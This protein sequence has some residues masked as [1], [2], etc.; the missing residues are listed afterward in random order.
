VSITSIIQ[1]NVYNTSILAVWAAV[2]SVAANDILFRHSFCV[3]QKVNSPAMIANALENRADVWSSLAVL[4]GVFGARIGF[5]VLDPVAAVIV[6]FMIAKNGIETLVL[7]IK[8]MTDGSFDKG[9]LAQVKK[10]VMEEIAIKDVSRLRSRQVGQK[11]W[12]DI[13]A[14]FDPK[15]KV[16][17]VKKIIE[18]I[19]KNIMEDFEKIGDVVIVSRVSEPQLKEI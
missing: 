4:A 11:N 5:P 9:M 8:G 15:I 19:R 6:G 1:G 10:I 7:G 14:M 16:S 18:R 2:I 12:I 17:E 3:G 13:E